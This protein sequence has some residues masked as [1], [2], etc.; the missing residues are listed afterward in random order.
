MTPT[1]LIDLPSFPVLTSVRVRVYGGGPSRRI[2]NVLSSISSTPALA[3]VDIQDGRSYADRPTR[4]DTWNDLD[5][6]L[7]QIAKH[8]AV[9]HGLVLNLRNWQFSGLELYWEALFQ[10]FREA[11]GKIKG[12]VEGWIEDLEI[13]LEG[14]DGARN[15]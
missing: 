3:F 13:F 15:C 1:P 11:G 7:A 6:W 5:R 8:T 2:V 10:R 9:E 12:H 4:S 14:C